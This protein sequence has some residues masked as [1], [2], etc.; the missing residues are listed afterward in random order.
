MIWLGVGFLGLII[1]SAAVVVLLGRTD[2]ESGVA[3]PTTASPGSTTATTDGGSVASGAGSAIDAMLPELQAFVEQERELEFVEP[4]DV[5]VLSADDYTARTLAQF[6]AD[7]DEDRESLEEAAAQYQALGLLDPDVDIVDTLEEF[8][9]TATAGFYDPETEELVVQGAELDLNLQ[10]TLVHELTHALDDQL[11]DLDRPELEDVEDESGFTF[12]ALVEGNAT[13]V[14]EA[15]IS[16]LDQD[17]LLQYFQQ[18]ADAAGGV[19]FDAFP[20]VLLIENEFVY[21][22]GFEFVR[23]LVEEGGN[24]LVDEVF[25][26]LPS[27]TEAILEPE[28]FLAAEATET[29]ATPAADGDVIDEGVA[30]QFLLELLINGTLGD[31]GV[32][33]WDGDRYVAWEDG[34]DTCVRVAYVG[35]LDALEEALGEWTDRTGGTL[36]RTGDTVTITGCTA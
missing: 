28:T 29:V 25:T 5:E 20:P 21:S 31:D 30:G 4:V 7:I 27:T 35:D 2:S 34:G 1:G 6:R 10:V 36:E 17:E 33:E 15:Y 9:S 23:A 22:N 26:D 16:T 11:F 14:E 12:S 18:A 3:S 8:Y 19:D 32:P 24:P 13:R